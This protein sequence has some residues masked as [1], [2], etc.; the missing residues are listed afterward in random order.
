MVFQIYAPVAVTCDEFDDATVVLRTA[1]FGAE[2]FKSV[3]PG[4]FRPLADFLAI[5]VVA[6][7][8][9]RGIDD[10]IDLRLCISGV[11]GTHEFFRCRG[12]ACPFDYGFTAFR[13][14]F[15]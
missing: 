2:D 9:V 4:F 14:S 8:F 5:V 3:P 10:M 6:L 1:R 15:A 13:I 7:G 12:F 11:S